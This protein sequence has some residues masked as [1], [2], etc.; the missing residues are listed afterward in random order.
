[1]RT[2]ALSAGRRIA[3]LDT[4][5]HAWSAPANVLVLLHAFPLTSDMWE[6]QIDS[7]P[8]GWRA[9]APDFR[10]FGSSEPDG[11]STVPS[12]DDYADDVLAVLDQA[13]IASACV[14]GLSMGGY[15]ALALI[16]KAPDRVKGLV[17]ADTRAEADSDAARASR[18]AMLATLAAGGVPAVVDLML[19]GL[20]GVTSRESRPAL[21]RRVRSLGL[22]QPAGAVRC[23]ID[24]LKTRPDAT[25]QLVGIAC[26]TLVIVGEEDQ[27]TTPDVARQ[28]HE[29]VAGSQLAVIPRSGHLSNLEQPEAFNDVLYGFLSRHW[30]RP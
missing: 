30:T 15:V 29:R 24:R 26:P 2:H 21:V 25:G 20:L 9:L 8:D 3:Y 6:P 16:R 28:L 4:H 19:P 11:P 5:H 10:G 13:G 22:A 18:D 12:I 27:I 17:L 1:M 14:A 7:L 23:A